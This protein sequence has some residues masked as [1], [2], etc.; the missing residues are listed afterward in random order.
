M[1]EGSSGDLIDELF[2]GGVAIGNDCE[3]VD[4]GRG[5]QSGVING[6]AEIVSGFGECIVAH[7]DQV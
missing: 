4:V 5:K 7:D 1:E 3:F 2:K 6:G